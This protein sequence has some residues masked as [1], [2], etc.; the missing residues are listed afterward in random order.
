MISLDVEK[1][2]LHYAGLGN[3]STLRVRDDKTKRFPVRDGQIG[4]PPRRAYEERLELE[5]RDLF[6]LHSDGLTTLRMADLKSGFFRRSPLLIA[7][8]LLHRFFRGRDDA[9]VVVVRVTE[10]V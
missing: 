5:T 8:V 4:G 1:G 9:S 3:I 7:G 2:A 10:E 6:I